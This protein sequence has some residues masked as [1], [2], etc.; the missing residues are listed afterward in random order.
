MGITT[1]KG[2]PTRIREQLENVLIDLEK[3]NVISHWAYAEELNEI[4]IGKRNWFQNYYSKLGIIILPPKE[5]M[6]N[7]DRMVKKKQ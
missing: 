4:K 5:L 2:R 6:N 7:I 3:E 1:T